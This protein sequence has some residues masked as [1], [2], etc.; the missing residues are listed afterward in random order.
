MVNLVFSISIMVDFSVSVLVSVSEG[1]VWS[2]CVS[3]WMSMSA[4]MSVRV[5]KPEVVSSVA[6]AVASTIAHPLIGFLIS[7]DPTVLTGI[8][9]QAI[10]CGAQDVI[11]PDISVYS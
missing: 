9:G 2:E 7:I 11:Y 10:G 6:V 3:T 1:S 4:S 8:S 5:S